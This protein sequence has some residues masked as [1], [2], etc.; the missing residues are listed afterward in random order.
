MIL[1]L[2]GTNEGSCGVFGG[3]SVTLSSAG[4]LL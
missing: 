1:P 3:D 2:N 4:P